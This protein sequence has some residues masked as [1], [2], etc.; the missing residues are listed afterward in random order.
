MNVIDSKAMEPDE[1]K[2]RADFSSSRSSNSR[3][4]RNGFRPELRNA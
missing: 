4:V 2:N 1:A 3:K